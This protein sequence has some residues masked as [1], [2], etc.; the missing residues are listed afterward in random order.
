MNQQEDHFREIVEKL[1]KRAEGK[2]EPQATELLRE[3]EDVLRNANSIPEKRAA[4]RQMAADISREA[5]ELI[6]RAA[7]IR[8]SRTE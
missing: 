5:R 8:N 1:H 7:E 4:N 6:Q 3:A 2:S